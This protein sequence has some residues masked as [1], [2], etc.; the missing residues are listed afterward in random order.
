VPVIIV[1]RVMIILYSFCY[2]YFILLD[3]YIFIIIFQTIGKQMQCD[4]AL[5]V[6]IRGKLF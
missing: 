1:G 6:S 2:V 5:H 3:V 4:D